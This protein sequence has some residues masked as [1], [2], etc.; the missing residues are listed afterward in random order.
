MNT[1]GEDNE[2]IESEAGVDVADALAS[3]SSDLFGQ[4]SEGGQEISETAS[5]SGEEEALSATETLPPD[6]SLGTE[7]PAAEE[8]SAEVQ[9]IGAPKTW[10]KEA[11]ADWATIPPRAQQEI[12]KREEDMFRGLEQYKEKADLGAKYDRVVEPYK[13]ILASQ[14]VDPVELFQN[15]AGN[16]YTLL[17]GSEAQKVQLA[18]NLLQ[19]Y[20]I[21]PAAVQQA[22]GPQPEIDP[23]VK[24]L[25]DQ[26]RNLEGKLTSREQMEAQLRTQQAQQTVEEFAKDKPYFDELAKDIAN[27]IRAGDDLQTAYDKALYANPITRGKEIER[28]TAEK[29]ALAQKETAKKVEAA[30][31]AQA[32]NVSTKP[33]TVDGTVPVGTMDDTMKEVMEKITSRG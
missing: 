25:Q 7:T 1:E 3:I 32:V 28:L 13:A 5:P 6:N 4:G 27:F 24:A 11:I 19:A 26:I 16:H 33:K 9:A 22:L 2:I 29:L 23:Q 21:N 8:N 30:K 10:S 20:G 31:R 14:N 17:N 18:A 12:L 15:F